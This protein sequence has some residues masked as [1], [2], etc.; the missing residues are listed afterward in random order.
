[1][2]FYQ[3]STLVIVLPIET[4]HTSITALVDTFKE[5]RDLANYYNVAP[6]I[7]VVPPLQAP[8]DGNTYARFN[9]LLS[10]LVSNTKTIPG[11]RIWPLSEALMLTPGQVDASLFWPDGKTLYPQGYER[12]AANLLLHA[13]GGITPKTPDAISK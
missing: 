5:L 2:G 4:L 12:L 9:R 13:Q 3:P 8:R 11:L 6:E 1:M 10:E 7:V